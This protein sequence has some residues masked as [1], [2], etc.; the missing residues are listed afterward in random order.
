MANILESIKSYPNISLGLNSNRSSGAYAEKYLPRPA[1]HKSPAI[2]EYPGII[3]SLDGGPSKESLSAQDW[4]IINYYS[5]S[6][7]TD[8]GDYFI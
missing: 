1:N 8:S 2:I 6:Q 3:N 4:D 7:A 5:P